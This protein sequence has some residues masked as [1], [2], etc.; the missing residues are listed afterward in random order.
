MTRKQQRIFAVI[1]VLAGAA[2]ATGLSL[3]ALRDNVTFFYSPSDIIGESAK[4][5]PP[6]NIFRLGGL[7][8]ENSV[9]RDGTQITFIIT[10]NKED[11]TIT[12]TGLLPDLFREG[13]GIIATGKMDDNG[14]FMASRLLAKHD[15]NYMPP[16]VA[17]ALDKTSSDK[18]SNDTPDA[19]KQ[20]NPYE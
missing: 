13:Q 20:D 12:Y 10:D 11:I 16:E 15:E 9:E 7:V 3:F 1:I 18:T 17:R 6:D 8:K 4:T 19:P 14:T 5:A 2:M